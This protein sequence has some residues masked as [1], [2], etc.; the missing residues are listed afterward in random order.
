MSR[1]Y[2]TQLVE[3]ERV[4]ASKYLKLVREE[5]TNIKSVRF[6]PPKVG[7]RRDFGS[8]VVEYAR[9]FYTVAGKS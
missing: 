9:P 2:D 1:I 8:F 3:W 5:Q 4:S 6:V 7:K